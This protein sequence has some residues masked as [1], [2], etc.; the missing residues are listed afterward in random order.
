MKKLISVLLAAVLLV[1]CFLAVNAGAVY[2]ENNHFETVYPELY[3][4]RGDGKNYPTII[5]PGINHSPYYLADE[6]GNPVLDSNG[7]AITSTLLMLDE[8]NLKKDIIRLVPRL[9]ASLLL[10]R[11]VG[12]A[13]GVSKLIYDLMDYMEMRPDGTTV[14]N[15][16]TRTF[17][18]PVS[19]MSESDK[20]FFYTMLPVEPIAEIC[21]EENLFLYT[22]PLFGDPMESAKGI[23]D[24]I[25]AVLEKT[26]AEK[27]NFAT[28]SLG[29]TMLAA[30]AETGKNLSKVNK[31]VNMVSLLNGTDIMADFIDR[32]FNVSDEFF[33][34]EYF[35]L[36]MESLTGDRTLGNLINILLHI[37]PRK[38]FEGIVSAAYGTLHDALIVNNPQFWAMVPAERYEALADK[39]IENSVLRAKTDAFQQARV[40]L[41]K[42]LSEMSKN[43]TE[44]FSVCGYNLSYTD[45][46]YAFFGVVKSS[47]SAN[48]D[49]IIPVSSTSLGA[50]A[51]KAKT[52]FGKEYLESH[53]SKYISPDK[54]V[55]ASTC[56]FPDRTWFFS[57][58]HHEVGRN[59]AVIRLAALILNGAVTDVYSTPLF[60]QFNGSRN[61]RSLT[62]VPS[63]KLFAALEA[64]EGVSLTA[65]Q[66]ELLRPAYENA[67]AVIRST[68]CNSEK[69]EK[70]QEELLDAMR[71]V[72]LEPEKEKEKFDLSKLTFIEKIDNFLFDRFGGEGFFGRCF[73][74]FEG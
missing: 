61:S 28:V 53:N 30:Y 70:A 32:D 67:L 33:R 12:A 34:E 40:N 71:K 3:E 48:S 7:K 23:D 52:Q 50:T 6:S 29:G 54:C 22:F 51:V 26:G 63:G 38:L 43:G 2:V 46:D 16:V 25:D 8:T 60:P 56:L 66:K 35:P 62:R 64:M 55:D 10:Q 74:F 69:T 44:V 59:D 19:E 4:L 58:Q 36:V 31:I 14:N 65:E 39:W 42:N 41:K 5:L 13:E 20:S 37:M 15:L 21:G 68:V 17:D 27:V 73:N 45:G 18:V 47:E 49:G 11:D 72:G 57:G 1:S 9:F 24:F